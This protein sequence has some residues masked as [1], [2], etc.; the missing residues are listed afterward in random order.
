[1]VSGA[2]AELLGRGPVCTDERTR[3]CATVCNLA[4]DTR[5]ATHTDLG[6]QEAGNPASIRVSGFDGPTNCRGGFMGAEGFEPG[7]DVS[8]I[9]C[10][11]ITCADICVLLCAGCL[12][13]SKLPSDR[14]TPEGTGKIADTRA[15]VCTI[16]PVYPRTGGKARAGAEHQGWNRSTPS[17]PCP[18][19]RR[20]GRAEAHQQR[21]QRCPAGS[22]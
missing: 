2:S 18:C 4:S 8:T 3:H 11:T 6:Y 15:P 19:R 21:I 14:S 20:R 16:K 13:Q 12:P 7:A 1:M 17:G 5:S 9:H 22:S 10:G